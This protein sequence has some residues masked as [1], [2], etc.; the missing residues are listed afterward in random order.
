MA[1]LASLERDLK[2]IQSEIA[3]VQV[4]RSLSSRGHN[5]KFVGP[6]DLSFRALSGRLQFTVRLHKFN[7][8]SLLATLILSTLQLFGGREDFRAAL[9]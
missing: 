6:V 7:K 4:C 2:A 3:F 8:D 1:Q 5:T 9:K